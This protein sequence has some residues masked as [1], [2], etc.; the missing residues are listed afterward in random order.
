MTPKVYCLNT[1]IKGRDFQIGKKIQ[2]YAIYN[3]STLIIQ[4]Y[5]SE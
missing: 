1:P 2:L 4:I 3:K 5:T